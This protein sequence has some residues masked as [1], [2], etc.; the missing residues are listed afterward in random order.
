MSANA[1]DKNSKFVNNE[2]NSNLRQLLNILNKV[3]KA[4][5]AS[6]NIKGDKSF[7]YFSMGQLSARGHRHV[8]KH[9]QKW[10]EIWKLT[11]S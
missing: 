3:I 6:F 10:R 1:Q 5:E 8:K 9:K 4:S 2:N 7:F 11:K